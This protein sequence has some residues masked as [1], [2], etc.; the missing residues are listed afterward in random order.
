[1]LVVS[2]LRRRRLTLLA[3]A[4]ALTVAAPAWADGTPEAGACCN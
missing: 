3:G 1:M 2:G 4:A